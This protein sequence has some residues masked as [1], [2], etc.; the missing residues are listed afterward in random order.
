MEP[1]CKHCKATLLAFEKLGKVCNACL[2]KRA[3][4]DLAKSYHYATGY[5]PPDLAE[6]VFAAR[7]KAAA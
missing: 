4:A 7:T 2:T 6:V 1:T 5:L 3:A